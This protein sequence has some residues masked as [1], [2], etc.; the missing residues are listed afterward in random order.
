M[1]DKKEQGARIKMMIQQE[2]TIAKLYTI[3]ARCFPEQKILWKDLAEEE[4][5]HAAYL[6]RLYNAL[7]RDDVGFSADRFSRKLLEESLNFIQTNIKKAKQKEFSALNALSLAL[8]LEKAMLESKFFNLFEGDSPQV[9]EILSYLATST[10]EHARKIQ[11]EWS[12][13]I[14]KPRSDSASS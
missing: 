4:R 9:T 11:D 6:K 7:K 12:M 3:F 2:K 14:K 5:E 1:T 13:R 10:N 8:S